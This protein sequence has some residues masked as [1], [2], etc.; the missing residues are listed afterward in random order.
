MRQV[1]L[2]LWDS[3]DTQCASSTQTKFTGGISRNLKTKSDCKA[4]GVRNS[5]LILFSLTI[6]IILSFC[7]GFSRELMQ[8]AGS[9]QGML[10][11]WSSIKDTSG[12]TTIDK[13]SISMEERMQHS[14]LPEPV[15][16]TKRVEIPRITLSMT[17]Y[18]PQRNDEKPQI[19]PMSSVS[20]YLDLPFT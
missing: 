6:F 14:D 1:V 8:A 18:C 3:S 7:W 11:I 16:D 4:S 5:N 9:Y 2:K 20:Y 10:S 17:S 15:Y 19:L 12:L 13:P